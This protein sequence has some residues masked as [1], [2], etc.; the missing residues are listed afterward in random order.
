MHIQVMEAREQ[1]EETE[2]AGHLCAM[3]DD[4]RGSQAR[5][6]QHLAEAFRGGAFA[7]A[8]RLTTHLT[9]LAKLEHEIK[10]KLPPE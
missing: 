10:S 7:D 3:L 6:V 5:V 8:V 9:Y 2:D 1:V 4:N